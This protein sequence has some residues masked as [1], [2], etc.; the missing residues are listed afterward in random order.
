MSKKNAKRIKCAAILKDGVVYEGKYHGAIFRD[1]GRE[2]NLRDGV[3]GF[4]T[5]CGKFVDRV[6]G[7]MIAEE[8]GQILHKHPPYDELMSEDYRCTSESCSFRKK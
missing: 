5:E 1:Y 3:Q 6:E 4:V 2:G 8:A 7:L